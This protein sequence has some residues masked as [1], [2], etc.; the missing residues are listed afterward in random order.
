MTNQT[1]I[2]CPKCKGE[3]SEAERWTIRHLD[4][5][6]IPY[7]E[8]GYRCLKCSESSMKRDCLT[9]EQV[10]GISG[11]LEVW[12]DLK[13]ELPQ[14]GRIV[15]V[16]RDVI[17]KSV[18]DYGKK[19]KEIRLAYRTTDAPYYDNKDPSQN[20]C[21]K[22]INE[23]WECS[24]SDMTVSGWRELSNP[25]LINV[26][27]DTSFKLEAGEKLEI[28]HSEAIPIQNDS[29][30]NADSKHVNDKDAV[31]WINFA[32]RKPPPGKVRALFNEVNHINK[33]LTFLEM[34]LSN[35]NPQSQIAIEKVIEALQSLIIDP[36]RDQQFTTTQLGYINITGVTIFNLIKKLQEL[37]K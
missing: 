27:V 5:N 36:S 28:S 35:E 30:S 32:D 20:C 17:S 6:E 8:V 13:N 21:W 37:N 16:K 14:K 1:K 11:Q 10:A 24:F 19:I 18:V 25:A 15:W 4:F 23:E 33:R 12:S 31:E 34:K 22:T 2:F 29:E 26:Y 7:Y 3:I 9:E